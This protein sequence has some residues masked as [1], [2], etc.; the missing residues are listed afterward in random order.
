[1]T[2]TGAWRALLLS[3][4]GRSIPEHQTLAARVGATFEQIAGAPDD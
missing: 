3:A 2:C 1:M 4:G